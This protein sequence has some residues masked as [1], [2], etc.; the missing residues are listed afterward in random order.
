[1][2][3]ILKKKSLYRLRQAPLT[4]FHHLG[5][6]LQHRGFIGFKPD[7]SLFYCCNSS[8]KTYVLVYVDDIIVIEKNAT[9]IDDLLLALGT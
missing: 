4:W 8:Y 5:G 2:F 9:Q 3:V 6:W 1:M 7:T